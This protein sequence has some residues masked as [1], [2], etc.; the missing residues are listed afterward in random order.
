MEWQPIDYFA[1]PQRQPVIEWLL[2]RGFVREEFTLGIAWSTRI[3]IDFTDLLFW[4]LARHANDTGWDAIIGC[5]ASG[6]NPRL[7][8]GTCETLEEV[9]MVYETIRLING[10]KQP[11]PHRGPE[12]A[13]IAIDSHA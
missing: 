9:Q 13:R 11:E 5:H 1:E 8:I 12:P 10:Y 2:S 7:H 4:P 3:G 6:L